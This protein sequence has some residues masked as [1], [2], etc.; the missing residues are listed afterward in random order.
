MEKRKWYTLVRDSRK[1]RM[2]YFLIG[3]TTIVHG[4]AFYMSPTATLID[5][6]SSW[7]TTILG[8]A[9]FYMGVNGWQHYSYSRTS[10]NQ[11]SNAS[12]PEKVEEVSQPVI[13]VKQPENITPKN[14]GLRHNDWPRQ[15]T[16]DFY[17]LFGTIDEAPD[18]IVMVDLPF[19]H[20][21]AWDL[22]TTVSRTKIHVEVKDSYLRIL[23]ALVEHYGL[24]RIEELRIDVWGGVYN[25]RKMKGS[26]DKWSNHSWAIAEDRDPDRNQ[27]SWNATQAAFAHKDYKDMFEIYEAEGWLS[28]GRARD[29]DWMHLQACKL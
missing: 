23:E 4:G 28:L 8:L 27:F 19:K 25:R 2:I 14:L 5:V 24:E 21:L 13:E 20:K 9:A 12:E 16:A 11:G 10:S 22:E 3:L 15:G 29:I 6:L 18:R 26:S 1:L 7:S 17:D